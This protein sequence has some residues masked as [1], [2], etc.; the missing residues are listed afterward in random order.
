MTKLVGD[1]TDSAEVNV[2]GTDPLDSDSDNDGLLDGEE[3]NVYLTNPL[4]PDS[5]GDGFNDGEEVAAGSD[6][7]DSSSRPPV[8]VSGSLSIHSVGNDQAA[9]TVMT[10]VVSSYFVIFRYPSPIAPNPRLRRD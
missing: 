3:V 2:H 4:N 9:A 7:N 10:L 5:D 6:P 8:A 1:L